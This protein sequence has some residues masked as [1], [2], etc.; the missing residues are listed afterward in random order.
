M[1]LE[2]LAFTCGSEA[3]GWERDHTEE[4][5]EP[6]LGMETLSADNG[7]EQIVGSERGMSRSPPVDGSQKNYVVK[8]A[9]S[10]SIFAMWA[11]FASLAGDT[12]TSPIVHIAD[13]TCRQCMFTKTCAELLALPTKASIDDDIKPPISAAIIMKSIRG[14]FSYISIVIRW[15]G[16]GESPTTFSSC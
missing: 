2:P 16:L 8:A 3:S 5:I 11:T 1:R 9:M 7:G 10:S 13:G 15:P 12:E 14:L 6:N 4:G